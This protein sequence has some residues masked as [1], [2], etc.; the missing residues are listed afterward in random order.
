MLSPR[1]LPRDYDN[2][3]LLSN[4]FQSASRALGSIPQGFWDLLLK[5]NL[6]DNSLVSFHFP[7]TEANIIFIKYAS[8]IFHKQ[9]ISQL[10]YKWI[11]V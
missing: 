9:D 2:E 8:S 1:K 5:N 11:N 3:I 10:T 6:K 7:G 4:R